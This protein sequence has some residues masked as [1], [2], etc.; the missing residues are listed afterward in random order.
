M[1]VKICG[2]MS[3]DVALACGELG[4]SALGLNFVPGSPRCISVDR[5]RE[6]SRAVRDTDVKVVGV[7]ADLD[8]AAMRK[9]AE[10][11]ELDALQLH[12]EETPATLDA[13]SPAAY[14][15]VRVSNRDDVERA[16]QFGGEP[17]LV[18]AKVDGALGGT[19]KTFDWALVTELA[20]Q[21]KIILAGGLRPENVARAVLAVDPWGVDVASGVEKSPGVKDLDKVRSF[22]AEAH[23]RR[24]R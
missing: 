3:V 4:A 23:V 10:E 19:G 7:V 15:A 21:R 9:L 12:G 11:A 18:D 8:V 14:K 2:I 5:A 22:I 24:R 16:R 13:L 1:H 6:I 20:Q 17:L